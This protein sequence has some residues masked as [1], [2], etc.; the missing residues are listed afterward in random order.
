MDPSRDPV[1]L[2]LGKG[3]SQIETPARTGNPESP[4][5]LTPC[6]E[7]LGRE[8]G[9]VIMAS[10]RRRT[11]LGYPRVCFRA[12]RLSTRVERNRKEVLLPMAHDTS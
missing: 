10:R 11:P 6:R 1:R 8:I 5:R 4:Q 2:I 3:R 12:S 9:K 7:T